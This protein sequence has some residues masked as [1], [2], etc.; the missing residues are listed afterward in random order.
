MVGMQRFKHVIR[1]MIRSAGYDIQR[2]RPQL[3]ETIESN[4]V[5]AQLQQSLAAK[6]S[7]LEQLQQSL[8]A[9]QS[10]LEQLQQASQVNQRVI[11]H[12]EHVVSKLTQR[13]YC[14]LPLPPE[15]LRMH[16][17][18]NATAANFWA[19]GINS[20]TRSI[21][22]FGEN[23]SGPILDWGCG[24]G[25]T[26]R[27]LMAYPSWQDYYCGCDVD[28]E[29]IEWLRTLSI[30]TGSPRFEVCGDL[31]PLPYPDRE[32]TGLFAY[33]VLTHIHP[34]RHRTWY[35]EIRRV[36]KP[37]GRAYLTTKGRSELPALSQEAQSHFHAHGWCYQAHEGEHYK[38][39]AVVCEDFTLEALRG[40]F[41][42]ED[43]K[44]L[45]YQNMDA[46]LV[47]RDD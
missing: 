12:C 47:R 7:H 35:E 6:Q 15:E 23:P 38:D 22:I 40:L 25:R 28:R 2:A 42:V 16:V 18:T 30:P 34:Q 20:S 19:Q 10:H 5:V 4:E 9:Q 26:F 45:G 32:F 36:L 21:E 41:I 43:Y 13:H 24:S 14:D 17:G 33:S 8:A 46:F 37:G 27:W 3:E 11:S 39:V 29:A 31:P 1:T 44:E